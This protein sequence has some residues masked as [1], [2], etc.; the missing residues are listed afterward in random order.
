MRYDRQ[1]K[2]ID[3]TCTGIYVNY[4]NALENTL[5]VNIELGLV[6]FSKGH[7]GYRKG[8]SNLVTKN[9]GMMGTIFH[10]SGLTKQVKRVNPFLRLLL[11]S[12]AEF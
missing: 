1:Y 3:L 5:I 8:I 6:K 9:N 2:N 10:F 7:L 11:L 4:F 12:V